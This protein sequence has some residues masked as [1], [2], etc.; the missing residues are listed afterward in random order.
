MAG[1][2]ASACS[3][4]EVDVSERNPLRCAA[5]S[6]VRGAASLAFSARWDDGIQLNET[7]GA[8]PRGDRPHDDR[9]IR[10]EGWIASFA[11]VGRRR[12]Y[13]RTARVGV[14]P[15]RYGAP[16]CS[17]ATRVDVAF[18]KHDALRKARRHPA[19]SNRTARPSCSAHRRHCI[20]CEWVST[21]SVCGRI[22]RRK[23]R[24]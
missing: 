16:P 2:V 18:A 20:A 6:R 3:M 7:H 10:R 12:I 5:V 17:E 19:G 11:A 23:H 15:T 1:R 22:R 24:W 21:P 9:C 4:R 13:P 8:R 14:L